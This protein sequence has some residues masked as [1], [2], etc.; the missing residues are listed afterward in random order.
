MKDESRSVT[1]ARQ[2]ADEARA[3]FMATWNELLSSID[4]LQQQ[5]TPSYIVSNAWNAAKN[6]GAHLA[7]GAVDSV[8][9][10]PIVAT[11]L[12]AAVTLFLTREPLRNLGGKLA[13]RRGE[14]KKP[15]RRSTK[16]K[17]MRSTQ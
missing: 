13:N 8:A 6:K 14:A 15:S 9:K 16:S 11:G 17:A 12:A 10:R 1:E 7:E 4:R 3:R 5:L 2:R